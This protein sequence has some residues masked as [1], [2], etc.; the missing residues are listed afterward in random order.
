MAALAQTTPAPAAPIPA[1][2]PAPVPAIAPDVLATA[3]LLRDRALA[4]TI[5]FSIAEGISLD[6]GPRV[7]GTPAEKK[8]VDWAVKRLTDL[9]FENVRAE[10][11]EMDGWVRGPE[12]A[13]I[14]APVPHDLVISG[15]GGS[16]AT[17]RGGIDAEVVVFATFDDLLDAPMGSLAGKIAMVTQAAIKHQDGAG[18]GA[19]VRIRQQG[20][21]EAARRGAVA[22]LLRSVGTHMDR[23]ANTGS[24][25]FAPDVPRIPSAAVSPPDAILIERLA[26]RGQPVRVR[27]DMQ[28][29]LPGKV[30]SHNVVADIRGA[31]K[32]D[33]FVIVSAHIDSWDLGQGALDDGA[34][35]GIVTAAAKLIRDL[36]Q[37]PRRTIRIIFFGAEEFGLLGARAYVAQRKDR[38]G[39]Y[40]VGSQADFGQEPAYSFLTRFNPATRAAIYPAM[41]RVLSPLNIITGSNEAMG[42]PDMTPFREAG[43]PVFTLQQAGYDYFDI[44][45]TPN[46]TVALLDARKL[47]KNVAAWAPITWIL[48]N[49][50]AD[51]R[52]IPNPTAPRRPN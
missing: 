15:L 25:R 16:P 22:Y 28:H 36:P 21:V 32:P 10:P 51:L 11:F 38:L 2:T 52:P 6:V 45:H 8:A 44:H 43:M 41:L 49:M 39:Q 27:L 42:G 34:G 13:S 29:R 17:P 24:M 4:G 50:D 20:P 3:A 5:A 31:E 46:D 26:A 9:G 48:A 12:R 40:Y 7:A 37:R 35:M 30:T 23:V 33:E 19:T 18:Y 47:D 1:A 14:L